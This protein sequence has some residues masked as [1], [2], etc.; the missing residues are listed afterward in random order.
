[1]WQHEALRRYIDEHRDTAS[2][3]DRTVFLSDPGREREL[4]GRLLRAL[5]PG[6][7]EALAATRWVPVVDG[8][9]GGTVRQAL[10]TRR[11]AEIDRALTF[12][13]EDPDRPRLP[14]AAPPWFCRGTLSCTAAGY[15]V[16]FDIFVGLPLDFPFPELLRMLSEPRLAGCPPELRFDP[17]IPDV[18]APTLQL[19]LAWGRGA[20]WSADAAAFA[21]AREATAN[22]AR[23]IDAVRD[24]ERDYTDADAYDRL[25]ERLMAAYEAF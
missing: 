2:F 15:F 9:D 3:A 1:M 14:G 24:L 8:A 19:G 4:D 11:S 13:V 25:C 10:R 5:W 7:L 16:A 6:V 12:L 18:G 22:N 20:S 21:A 17:G 23:V